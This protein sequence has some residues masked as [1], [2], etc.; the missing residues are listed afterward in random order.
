MVNVLAVALGGAAGSVLRYWLGGQI[1]AATQ[2]SFPLGTVAVNVLG[3]LAIGFL[4]FWFAQR[5]SL[6]APLAELIFVGLLGGFTTF[7]TFSLDTLALLL[8]GQIARALIYIAASLTLCLVAVWMGY[9]LANAVA[10]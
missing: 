4:Y 7:S 10:A 1:Q 5:Q 6:G 9:R 8:Q 2:G 3:S